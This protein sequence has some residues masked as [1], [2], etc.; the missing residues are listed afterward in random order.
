MDRS[1][2]HIEH[3]A[4]IP[5]HILVPETQS[6]KAEVAKM[7][8]AT[9][10]GLAAGVLHAIHFD[11]QSMLDADEFDDAGIDHMLTAKLRPG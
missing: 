11:D 1:G 9:A 5:K 8:V 2:N 4:R 3:A 10:I 7:G 6:P